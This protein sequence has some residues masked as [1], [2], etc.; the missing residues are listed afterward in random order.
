MLPRSPGHI[1]QYCFQL[2]NFSGEGTIVVSLVIGALNKPTRHC[3][4]MAPVNPT[5]TRKDSEKLRNSHIEAP[6]EISLSLRRAIPGQVDLI[7]VPSGTT[8]LNSS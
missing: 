8:P 1:S 2:L 3:Q 6:I 5:S 7:L 4:I